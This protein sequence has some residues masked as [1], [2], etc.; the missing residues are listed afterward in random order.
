MTIDVYDN[1]HRDKWENK[2]DDLLI[3]LTIIL[4]KLFAEDFLMK[5]GNT[6]VQNN[7]PMP[8]HLKEFIISFTSEKIERSEAS[9]GEKLQY[10]LKK[11]SFSKR[12]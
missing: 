11:K 4:K 8:L 10:M 12:V 3:M 6:D 9:V 1:L 7:V 5:I 2:K